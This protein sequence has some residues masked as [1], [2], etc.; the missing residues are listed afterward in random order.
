M[1]GHSKILAKSIDTSF[2]EV[3]PKSIGKI[4][5]TKKIP[6]FGFVE[7]LRYFSTTED[8]IRSVGETKDL[9]PIH[10]H[11]TLDKNRKITGDTKINTKS[12]GIQF[13]EV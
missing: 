2:G 8:M 5:I 6:N 9:P 4:Y 7:T 13:G 12:I 3:C 10:Q 11:P 1:A